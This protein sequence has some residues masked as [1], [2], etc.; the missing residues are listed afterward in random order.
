MPS[1][2]VTGGT[3][4]FGRK[5]IEHFLEKGWDVLFTSTSEKKIHQIKLDFQANE[6]LKGFLVDFRETDAIPSLLDSLLNNYGPINHL[7]NNAR[8]MESLKVGENGLTSRQH[9]Q[10]EFLIDVIVPYELSMALATAQEFDLKTIVNIGSQYGVVAPNPALYSHKWE[11]SPIQYGVSKA[12]LAHLTKELAVRLAS[13]NIRVNSIAY[14]GVEGRVTDEFK[15]LYANLCPLGRM[16]TEEE[17]A[18]P[19]DYLVTE[20]SSGMT[21]QTLSVDGGWTLW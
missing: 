16:L 10:E 20:S 9:F 12:A 2:F 13:K 17:I 1:I 14:G 8:S 4:K 18:G 6:R 3:G 5:I 19:I 7:V 21:G 15:G 11:K